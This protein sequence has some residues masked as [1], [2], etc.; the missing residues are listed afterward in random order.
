MQGCFEIM[1]KDLAGR[2]GKLY[3]PHGIVE[4][5]TLMPVVNPHILLL[6]PN[7]LKEVGADMLITNSY[8]IHQDTSFKERALEQGVHGLLG[9]D[10]PIMTDS[11]AFQLSV[12][13][14]IDIQPLDILRFQQEIRSDISVPL[15]IPTG[16]DAP[17]EQAEMELAETERRLREAVENKERDCC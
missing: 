17:R 16:P 8:I 3:T 9:Y 12:Y 15:D 2:V 5:P 13:G 4:T 6:T 1:H 7:E 10:G 11:G 14:S